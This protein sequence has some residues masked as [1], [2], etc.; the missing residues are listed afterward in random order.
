MVMDARLEFNKGGFST[1]LKTPGTEEHCLDNAN[2][3]ELTILCRKNYLKGKNN[4]KK[5]R[6]ES[7]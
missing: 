1:S 4:R 7:V 5:R 3:M 6:I 2:V